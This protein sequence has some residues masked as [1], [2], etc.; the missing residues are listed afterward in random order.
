[1]HILVTYLWRG[2][3]APLIFNFGTVPSTVV[4][5]M[6]RLFYVQAYLNRTVGGHI[7]IC[8][9]YYFVA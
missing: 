2:V 8:G 1:M 6:L 3:M 5:L 9:P 7:I 4:S